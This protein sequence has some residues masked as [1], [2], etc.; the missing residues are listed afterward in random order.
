MSFKTVLIVSKIFV[1]VSSVISSMAVKLI[2]FS[3]ISSV[4]SSMAVKSL[5]SPVT[6]ESATSSVTVLSVTFSEIV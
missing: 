3:A 1:T 6:A 4:M 2:M 5:M